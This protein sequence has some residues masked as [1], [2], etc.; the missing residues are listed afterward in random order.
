MNQIKLWT[1]DYLCVLFT[2]FFAAVTHNIF[3]S[4]F[5]LYVVEIGGNN[6]LAGAMI[7]GL[8][9]ASTITRLICGSLLDRYGRR[10][11]LIIGGFL[12]ALNTIAY[13][14]VSTIPG[15]FMLRIFNGISQGIYFGA[16]STMVADIVPEDRLVDGIGYFGIAGS[17]AAAFAPMIGLEIFQNLGASNLFLFVSFFATIGALFTLWIK[18]DFIPVVGKK[19][20]HDGFKVPKLSMLI[21]FSVLVPAVISFFITF[22]NSSV[23]NFLAACGI[24]RGITSISLFFMVN[25]ISMIVIRLFTGRLTHRYGLS[26]LI[27]TGAILVGI[28]FVM[29][30]FAY[31]T[32]MIIVA[33]I[34]CG[35]GMGITTPLLN[36]MIFKI[37]DPQRKGVANSTFALFGDIGNGI[38]AT[39]WGTLSQYSGYT[40]TYLVSAVCIVFAI[41]IHL[42]K[43][44]PKIKLNPQ[45]DR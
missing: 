40:I 3:I 7:T 29:I 10:K 36:A 5:P 27:F 9:I 41:V 31:D 39:V 35:I 33:G 8:V 44:I 15:L 1:K 26:R 12:F 25:S 34:L 6:A 32:F 24:E 21:E 18:S 14:F 17:L 43:L 30:A 37:A 20:N 4:I 42:M 28:G 45:Y 16:A 19:E 38:G 22:G 11:M 13:N 23:A 2:T